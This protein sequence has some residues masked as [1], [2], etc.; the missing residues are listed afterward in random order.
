M[1][2]NISLFGAFHTLV[3]LIP[4]GA[5]LYAFV[6]FGRID[7]AELS[8]KLYLVTMFIGSIT[9][10][11]LLKHDF[12]KGHGLSILT[13]LLLG[14]G[15]FAPRLALLGRKTE[16]VRTISLS[17]TYL[18]LWVFTTTETLTR[19][20]VGHPYAANADDLKLM[21]IRLVLLVLFILGATLQ[22]RGLRS[23]TR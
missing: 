23:P 20:P 2:D 8:G 12:N 6:R 10:F 4:I 19:I 13:L 14:V 22:V 5:G 9:A 7:P 15:W 17:A 18:L 21:P 1:F 16:L 11:G 3:S